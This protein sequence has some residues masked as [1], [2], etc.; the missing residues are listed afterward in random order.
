MAL[1]SS[2]P[3]NYRSLRTQPDRGVAHNFVGVKNVTIRVENIWYMSE[4]NLDYELA[5]D[6]INFRADEDPNNF[7]TVRINDLPVPEEAFRYI[8]AEQQRAIRDDRFGSF[9]TRGVLGG[10]QRRVRLERR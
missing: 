9:S 8:L 2:G 6:S 4:E 3:P 1:F 7:P 10:E 5:N